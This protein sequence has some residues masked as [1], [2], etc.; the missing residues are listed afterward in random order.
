MQNIVITGA[1][2]L[3][4]TELT[5]RLLSQPDIHLILLSTHPNKLR[6]RYTGYSNVHCFTL[7]D[8]VTNCRCGDFKAVIHTAFAR[9][10]NGSL[11]VESVNYTRR[12]LD[13]VQECNVH[14]FINISS[15]SVYGVSTPPMWRENTPLNPVMGDMYALAKTFTETLVNVM[16]RDG[17]TNYTNIRLSSVC[18][19]AR[20]LRVFVGKALAGEP[21]QVQGGEQRFSFIDVRDVSSAL[22]ALI[23]KSD[24]LSFKP[25]YN[26]GT[27]RQTSLIG[28]AEEVKRIAEEHYHTQ[29]VQILRTSSDDHRS[30]GMDSSLFMADFS[31]KPALSDTDM[32]ISLFEYLTNINNW[33]GY[34]IAFKYVYAGI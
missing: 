3:I 23:E 16:L 14:S 31:W 17:R 30:V 19:N 21:I 6:Q 9:S 8:F 7:D 28:L 4:A 11:L 24:I 5:F 25:V 18:E 20:F 13:F 2:G 15:Q 29:P 26:L 10:N 22:V 32:I 33:G 1:S 34:P 12:L 27:G